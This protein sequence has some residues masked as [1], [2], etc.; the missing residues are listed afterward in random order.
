MFKLKKGKAGVYIQTQSIWKDTQEIWKQKE[1]GFFFLY[2]SVSCCLF[3][4]KLNNLDILSRDPRASCNS[5][6]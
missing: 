4:E 1:Q 3:T 6:V 5:Y 2:Y